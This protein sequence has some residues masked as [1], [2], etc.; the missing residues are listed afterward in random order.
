M[1]NTAYQAGTLTL[2]AAGTAQAFQ[3]L[4]NNSNWDGTGCL[5]QLQVDPASPGSIYFGQSNVSST[6]YGYK[7]VAG[8]SRNY[9]PFIVNLSFL[10]SLYVV[11]DANSC[12]LHYEIIQI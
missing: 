9:G 10:T 4:V 3:A 2:G 6:I 1:P 7:L 11:G 8:A 5:V 12:I